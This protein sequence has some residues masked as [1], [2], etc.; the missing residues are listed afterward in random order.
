MKLVDRQE[1]KIK[2]NITPEGY[3]MQRCHIARIGSM[4][5][6][7]AE[8]GKT[9]GVS[10]DIYTD[11]EELFSTETMK[12]YEGVPVTMLHPEGLAVDARNWKTSAIGTARNIAPNPDGVHLDADIIINDAS[13]IKM[14]QEYGIRELSCGH[15]ADLEDRDGRIFKKN[16]R[17]NHVA[18][19]PSARAGN[20]HRLGDKETVPM[21]K[22]WKKTLADS[23]EKL[24]V[25]TKKLGDA[26]MSDEDKAALEAAI[27]ELQA[28][29]DAMPADALPEEVDALKAQI[30]ELQAKLGAMGDAK[31][32]AD[33]DGSDSDAL[34]AENEAL[35]AEIAALKKELDEL[36]AKN[37]KDAAVADA[38]TRF[39]ASKL[40]DADSARAVYTIVLADKKAF[41]ADQMKNMSDVEIRAA[42]AGLVASAAQANSNIGKK[43]F[44][45]AEPKKMDLTSKFS[46][47]GKKNAK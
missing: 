2:F 28:V 31:P 14:V 45:D 17:G 18:V 15:D 13:G 1:A 32:K 44:A 20:E 24:K 21:S 27:A 33:A 26:E 35:K 23:I 40:A 19:V 9:A 41:T 30:A 36:K 37:D 38:T 22:K 3:L 47:K 16:K 7:G 6:D 29:L 46:R 8:I 39:P 5:Y 42:Y 25:V 10:Y 11:A 4:K 34:K 43:L 12:S